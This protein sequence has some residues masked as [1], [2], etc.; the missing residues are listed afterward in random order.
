MPV[1]FSFAQTTIRVRPEWQ[2]F[3]NSANYASFID[4]IRLMRA[5][6]NA[7]SPSSWQYW[8]NVHVNYC[9]HGAPYFLAWHR[10]YLYYFEQQLR[11]VS[12]N[13][14]LVLPYWDYYRNPRIPAEFTDPARGNPL[15]VARVN[16]N[17]YN[18]LTLTPFGSNVWNFQR[19]TANAFE[20]FLEDAPH[21]PVHNIIGG[22]M[23]TMQS[24]QD[25]IFYLH[26]A[27]ID[28]LW[29]AWALPDGKGIPWTSS[30][31]WSGNFTYAPN[32]TLPRSQ[33]YHPNWV[34]TDYADNSPPTSL[35][36]QAMLKGEVIRVQS[37]QARGVAR[38]P[39]GAFKST[40][41][42]GLGAGRRS[43]GGASDVGLSESSV[44]VRVPVQK[45]DSDALQTIVAHARG[46]RAAPAAAP[47]TYKSVDITLDN[48]NLLPPGRLGGFY[49]KVYLNLPAGG[50]TSSS[51][52]Y[53][54]GTLGAF[55][56]DA[57]SH[58]GGGH[59]GGGTV[60]LSFPATERLV[61]IMTND[62]RE[63][64]VSLVR[65]NGDNSPR[66]RVVTI[67]ELRVELSTQE[68]FDLTPPAPAPADSPYR[69]SN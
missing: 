1:K 25:P 29:H 20:T 9:P 4:A 19:G 59:H 46:N 44:S 12:G 50:A 49:Y 41:P 69:S 22:V 6:T 8:V 66:G 64:T 55:E 68:P 11:I 15:Y 31:Y 16:T 28:R 53:Y 63:V 18:A 5:N 35:P 52:A 10:G 27:N 17:V 38:P 54:L 3:R 45:Q 26:H 60:Q 13:N 47:E 14:N 42:K 40:A 30:P 67:G 37:Q 21:N 51:E 39:V 23:Q 33:C 2:Q 56:I 61:S 43:I 36:P 24:P 57:A 48:V 62:I 34:G 58:R 32:L 65:V 7:S